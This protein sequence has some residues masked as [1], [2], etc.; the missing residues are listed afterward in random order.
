MTAEKDLSHSPVWGTT[1]EPERPNALV[2]RFPVVEATDAKAVVRPFYFDREAHPVPFGRDTRITSGVVYA[3]SEAAAR[4]QFNQ[5]AGKV[6]PNLD[7]R[8][9]FLDL[10]TV[11]E[12]P[13]GN[14]AVI[15][16][17]N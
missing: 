4:A 10:A 13:H 7:R 2:G 15:T 17:R 9:R 16:V 3:T 12:R 11:T 14:I 8:Y 5:V 6:I 1:A